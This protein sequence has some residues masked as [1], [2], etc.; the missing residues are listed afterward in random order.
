MDTADLSMEAHDGI[1]FE[2][3]KFTHDLTLYYGLLAGNCEDEAEY[4]NKAEKMT[5][6]IMEMEEYELDDLFWGNPPDKRDLDIT[7]KKILQNI[8]KVRSIPISER[9]FVF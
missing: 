4:L 1:L 9:K 8:E 5:M 2:A 3:E 7:C 6:E